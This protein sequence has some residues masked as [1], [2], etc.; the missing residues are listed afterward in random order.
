[1]EKQDPP[2]IVKRVSVSAR[3]E[4]ELARSYRG[5]VLHEY[6]T[7]HHGGDGAGGF[8]RDRSCGG[9][10]R[11]RATGRRPGARRRTWTRRGGPDVDNPTSGRDAGQGRLVHD[12]ELLLRSRVV[13]R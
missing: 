13:D 7:H 4:P 5:A 6:G 11:R 9:R 1:S 10:A 3:C 8:A 2:Y 12:Q